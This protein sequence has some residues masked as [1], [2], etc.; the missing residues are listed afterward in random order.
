[1]GKKQVAVSLRKPPPADPD[2]FVGSAEPSPPARRTAEG[3]NVAT[4][5]GERRELTVYLP[6]DLARTLSV[7]CLELDRDV[8]NIVAEALAKSLTAEE[9]VAVSLPVDRWQ[10]VRSLLTDLRARVPW[11]PLL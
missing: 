2:A 10:R 7:R 9:P 6:V 5:I 11:I 1:M 4:R 8:S 3:A